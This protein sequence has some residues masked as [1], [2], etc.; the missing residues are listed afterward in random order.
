MSTKLSWETILRSRLVL[1][2]CLAILGFIALPAVGQQADSAAPSPAPAVKDATP[3]DAGAAGVSEAEQH[4]RKGVELYNGGLYLE[5]L[6]EFNRALALDPQMENAKTYREKCNGKLSVGAAGGDATAVPTF[7]TLDPESVHTE[8]ETPQLSAEELKIKRVA[9]LLKSAQRYLDAERYKRAVQLY[10]EVLIIAP[11]N[12]RALEGLHKATIG[13]SAN[14]STRA[15]QKVEEGKAMINK[16]IEEEKQ[17]PEGAD[18]RG[19][20]PYR[21]TVPFV[22]EEYVEPQKKSDIEK[23]LDSPVGIEFENIHLSEIVEFISDSWDVNIVIDDRVV[24]RPPKNVP[25][26]VATTPTAGPGQYPGMPGVPGAPG[27]FPG[28]PGQPGRPGAPGTIGARPFAP[29]AAQQTTT[30]Q[31]GGDYGMGYVTDG[32]V[33]YINLKDVTMREA[34][35]ALLRPLNLDFAV[36]PGFIWISTP[37]RIREE[38]FEEL[39]TRYYE[40]RNAGAETLYK[41]VLRN[42]GGSGGGMG[43]YGGGMGGYGGGRMGGMGGYGGGMGGMGG[44]MGG[45]GGGMGGG[46]GGM[47]GYGGGMGGMGGYGGGMGGMGGGMGG[48]GGGMGG[49]GGYGGGMGGRMGGMGGYGGG[50]GGIQIQNIAQLFS[51]VSDSMVGETPAIIGTA[52]L[53]VGGTGQV[54]AARVGGTYGGGRQAATQPAG[55]GATAGRARN[56]EGDEPEIVRLLRLLV[57][58]VYEPGSDEPISRMIYVP[59][60]NQLI[61]HNTPTNLGNLE[62][63]LDELDIT[64]KQVSIEAK[65]LTIKNQDLK[66]IGFKYNSSASDLNG[67]AQQIPSLAATTYNYDINGDGVAEAIPFYQRPDG[68]NVIT[69]TVRNAVLD[70]IA[71]PNPPGTF[72]L[73]GILTNNQD[74]D[75]ISATFDYL[76]Q[77][78]ESELLSAPRVT[79]MNRKPAVIADLTTEYFVSQVISE[80]ISSEAGFGGTAQLGYTQQVVPQPFNFGI[81]LSVTPQISG[82]D[83]VRLWLNPQVTTRGIQKT[84][85][86]RSVI[87]GSEFT[88]TITLPNTSTQAVWTNVIV[89]DGDTLVLG[90]LVSDQTIKSKHKLPYLADIPIVGFFFQGK[91]KQANQSSLLIFVTPTIIDTTGSR[92]FEAGTTPSQSRRISKGQPVTPETVRVGASGAAPVEA[93]A[94]PATAPS[95]AAMES[96]PAASEAPKAAEKPKKAKAAS[97]KKAGTS[98]PAEL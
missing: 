23:L 20:K 74:G 15:Q 59:H 17:L 97:N 47:G 88:S 22:G 94:S 52:G 54:G 38:S 30:N 60:T 53:S 85:E 34:L 2:A 14:S 65:F 18:A 16:Y 40:L 8:A 77:L 68:S 57:N 42:P 51:T 7:D 73:T 24:K 44:G 10:E 9:E 13:A 28:A 41:I 69:N 27:A 67:R 78:E 26:P 93:E 64:P 95:D 84:F 71:S 61:V 70:A 46:M 25:A 92:F 56:A 62:K 36:Q 82:S 29:M 5:A 4:F 3:P 89:H 49:M 55:T 83:Q 90:G 37:Q 87:G 43:G 63:Q 12:E 72:T 66:K 86:Q 80:V 91:S 21:I 79:T 39:E 76:N 48:Y 19:I 98:G 11:D 45:Y 58:D 75:K 96:A 32:I 33:P 31:G 6:S 50:M 81:T 1:G 35:K